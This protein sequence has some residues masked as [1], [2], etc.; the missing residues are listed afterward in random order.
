MYGITAYVWSYNEEE[1]LPITLK[2]LEGF[3]EIIVLDKSS[4]DRS[5]DIAK[6]FGCKVFV[7]P[8]F[9]SFADKEAAEKVREIWNQCENEWMF[10]VT[11]SDVY[12]P[13][14]YKEMKSII[15]NGI[16][17]DVVYIPLYRY[18]MGFVSKHSFYGDITYQPKLFKKSIYNWDV[19]DL[20]SNPLKH[21]KNTIK[22]E[23]KDKNIAIYHLTHETLEL[24]MERHLRYARV[25]AD[26]DRKKC[27]RDE[28]LNRS[29]RSVLR[30]V[31]NYIKL[32]TYKLGNKGKAQLCMLLMYRCANYLHLYFDK[33]E[34]EFIHDTYNRIRKGDFDAGKE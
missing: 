33:K 7:L 23:P 17:A 22:L 20:H 34:E 11:C 2:A 9:D 19:T 14:L 31:K 13:N 25:E 3:D 8:Y 4:Q 30:V 26:A 12:H 15:N 29:W 1:R 28:Y 5:V 32:G 10:Q 27:S 6:Q 21:A 18:S 24:V 16:D